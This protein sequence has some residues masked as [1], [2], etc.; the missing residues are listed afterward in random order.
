MSVHV[1]TVSRT[2]NNKYVHTPHGLMALRSF[3]VKGTCTLSGGKVSV[4]SIK[5]QI[6]KWISEESPEGPLS[7]EQIKERVSKRFQVDISR[8]RVAQHRQEMNIAS[9]RIRKLQYLHSQ[10]TFLKSKISSPP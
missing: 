6:K 8:R 1:S 5:N 4:S 9:F 10:D 7:D 3:F 2:V